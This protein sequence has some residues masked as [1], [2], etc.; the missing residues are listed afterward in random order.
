MKEVGIQYQAKPLNSVFYF[1]GSDCGSVCG[2]EASEEGATDSVR[3]GG[4]Q[5]EHNYI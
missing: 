3:G 1:F 5:R 2:A 4:Y